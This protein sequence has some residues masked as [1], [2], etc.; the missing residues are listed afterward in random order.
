MYIHFSIMLK[1]NSI[2]YR[3]IVDFIIDDNYTIDQGSLWFL[4]DGKLILVDDDQYVETHLD[5]SM[6]QKSE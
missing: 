1:E 5:S 4:K 2:T 6:F 3:N